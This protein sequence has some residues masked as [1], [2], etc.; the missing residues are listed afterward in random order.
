MLVG[1]FEMYNKMSSEFSLLNASSISR[2]REFNLMD[3]ELHI[4][5]KE[6]LWFKR[7][8]A[9]QNLGRTYIITMAIKLPEGHTKPRVFLETEG[10]IRG[11]GHLMYTST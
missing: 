7:T 4:N 1:R 9:G 11:M 5:I 6:Q 3:I 2:S 8:H 10:G